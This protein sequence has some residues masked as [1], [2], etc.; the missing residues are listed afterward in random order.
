MFGVSNSDESEKTLRN[1]L[2]GY[3]LNSRGSCE[4]PS[5]P[6]VYS[7]PKGDTLAPQRAREEAPATAGGSSP[8]KLK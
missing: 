2:L 4:P 8:I 1:R 7:T 5:T 6:P 3:M